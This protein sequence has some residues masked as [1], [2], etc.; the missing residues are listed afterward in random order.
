MP[1]AGASDYQQIA[2]EFAKLLAKREY[3]KAYEMMSRGYRERTT[4]EQLRASFETIVPDDW[5]STGPIEVGQTMTRWPG[6]Q[7]ADLGWVYVSIGGDV[8][9]EAITVVVT[10]ESGIARIRDV[11]FGRP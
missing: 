6:K 11:E 5:G 9:S 7:A 8:Y 4:A 1:S 2:L 10:S 3:P